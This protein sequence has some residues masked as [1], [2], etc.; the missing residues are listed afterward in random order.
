VSNPFSSLSDSSKWAVRRAA[1]VL[2]DQSKERLVRGTLAISKKNA[3]SIDNIAL[4]VARMSGEV[5]MADRLVQ[6]IYDAMHNSEV[7]N[8]SGGTG[9]D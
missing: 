3:S 1:V 7:K 4:E 8:E 2:L 9:N 5:E 6:L